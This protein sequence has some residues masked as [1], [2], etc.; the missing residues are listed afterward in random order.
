MKK[1]IFSLCLLAFSVSLF[2]QVST[3]PANSKVRKK[4]HNLDSVYVD[5]GVLTS[6]GNLKNSQ[7]GVFNVLDYGADNTGLGDATTAI[8]NACDAAYT[9]GGTVIGRGT[10]KISNTIFIR[11]N[12]DFAGAHFNLND[13]TKTA[14]AYVDSAAALTNK[15]V[16]F[17][18]VHET[19]THV[20]GHWIGA[21]IGVKI[22]NG[23]YCRFYVPYVN[24]FRTGILFTTYG[25]HGNSYN[26]INLGL[27]MDNKIS[28]NLSPSTSAGWVNENT[29]YS[30]KVTL[31]GANDGATGTR[32]IL[33]DSTF[34]WTNN[35]V[36][37]RTSLESDFQYNIECFG[38]YNS[39][40]FCRFEG[41]T[42]AV[43]WGQL[44]DHSLYAA[45]N[46]VYRG[47]AVTNIT[48][49]SDAY[50]RYNGFD[51]GW[52]MFYSGY[53]SYGGVNNSSDSYMEDAKEFIQGVFHDEEKIAKFVDK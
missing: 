1:I 5:K 50:C 29:W 15:V 33:I 45:N 10:F 30:G 2:A 24:G 35:N 3:W 47:Y 43:H 26:E 32:G 14:I 18:E 21:S 23:N 31:F 36:F 28:I 51:T 22:V 34:N 16:I 39:F 49:T 52:N 37:I 46:I 41:G 27:I 4:Q 12:A 7:V 48:F 40:F 44:H 42:P 9:A 25:P 19:A 20:E 53:Y 17:P 6:L 13:S 11:S 38:S 8:N